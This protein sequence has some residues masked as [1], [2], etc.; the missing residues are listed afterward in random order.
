M[1][2]STLLLA[3]STALILPQPQLAGRLVDVDGAMPSDRRETVLPLNTFR[4]AAP[5]T[6][7]A[8]MVPASISFCAQA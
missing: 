4:Q 5:C 8:T 7:S 3:G 1:A 2:V 6:A